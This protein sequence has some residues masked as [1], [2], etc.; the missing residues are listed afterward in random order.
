MFWTVQLQVFIK[1]NFHFCV[2]D[3]YSDDDGGDDD[4]DDDDY[5]DDDDDVDDDDGD[6]DDIFVVR[7]QKCVNS[8]MFNFLKLQYLR[9][10][11]VDWE[12]SVNDELQAVWRIGLLSQSRCYFAVLVKESMEIA[13]DLSQVSLLLRKIEMV[14]IIFMPTGII[15][16]R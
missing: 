5:D 7:K 16:F 4:D 1:W 9:V 15:S 3:Y 6:Y 12:I 11:C 2:D 14:W 8:F 13:R 10:C